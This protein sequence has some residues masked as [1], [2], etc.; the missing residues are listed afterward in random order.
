MAQAVPVVVLGGERRAQQMRPAWTWS[1]DVKELWL[2]S[3][4]HW[5]SLAGSEPWPCLAGCYSHLLP[6]MPHPVPCSPIWVLEAVG[7]TPGGLEALP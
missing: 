6:K 1:W 3:D 4:L 7:D 2:L 5:W